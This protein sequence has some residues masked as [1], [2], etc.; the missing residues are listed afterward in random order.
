MSHGDR[1]VRGRARLSEGFARPWVR[2]VAL[3]IDDLGIPVGLV[4]FHGAE[5]VS[6]P[7]FID[8]NP[9][10]AERPLGARSIPT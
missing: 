1:R 7:P 5:D 8:Q 10:S 9:W 3:T 4:D 6:K 2:F